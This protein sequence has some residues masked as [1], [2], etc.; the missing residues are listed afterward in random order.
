LTAISPATELIGQLSYITIDVTGRD[1]AAYRD[2]ARER[3]RIIERNGLALSTTGTAAELPLPYGL[4]GTAHVAGVSAALASI[5]HSSLP[6]GDAT[7]RRAVPIALG[8]LPFDRTAPT[9][10]V[11]PEVALVE[12]AGHDGSAHVVLTSASPEWLARMTRL[13]EEA[14]SA[15]RELDGHDELRRAAGWTPPDSFRLESARPHADFRRLVAETVAAIR[16]SDLDKVVLVR[17]VAVEANR[18]L[19]PGSLQRALRRLYPSCAAFSLDGFVGASPESLVERTGLTLSSHPL[20][21]TVGRS[22][23][24]ETDAALEEALL[25]SDKDQGEHKVVVD[26]IAGALRSVCAVLDVPDE[27]SIVRLRNV[28]H[29]GTFVTGRLARPVSSIE[30]AALLHPTPAVAGTPTEAALEWIKAHERLDRGPYGGPVGWVDASGDGE[31]FVGIRAALVQGTRARL[32]AGAGIVAD[33]DPD[34]E[35]VETQLKLQ[36]L[37]AAAVRP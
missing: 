35:L 28:S 7:A 20:A 36:A 10:L 30:L 27:P 26:A 21:G 23:D 17:E 4:A 1:L 15:P 12:R 33:S 8:A 6:D 25:H 19:H 34:E 22:G 3:G 14:P 24:D 32:F 11:V 2:A 29:L 18:D 16:T 13:W 9:R 5:P 31:W 37:L